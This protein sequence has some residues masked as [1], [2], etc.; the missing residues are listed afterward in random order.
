MEHVFR[1]LFEVVVASECRER[2]LLR[3]KIDLEHV[4]FR[5]GVFE[6]ALPTTIVLEGRANVPTNLAV[7]A[8]GRAG[9]G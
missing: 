9:F 4:P 2:D 6:V 7:F 1:R 5:H 8:V 3:K